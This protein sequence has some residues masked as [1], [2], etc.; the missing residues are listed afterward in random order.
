[1]TDDK[2]TIFITGCNGR[3][4][5][6]FIS[7]FSNRYNIIGLSR[8]DKILPHSYVHVKGDIGNFVSIINNLPKIDCLINNAVQY[9]IHDP[10]FYNGGILNELYINLAIP[11]ELSCYMHSIWKNIVGNFSILNI[12][13]IAGIN[14]Y[15]INQTTYAMCKTAMNRM[16]LDMNKAFMP[17]VRVNAIAPNSFPSYIATSK[18]I[19]IMSSIIDSENINGQIIEIDK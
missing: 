7:N 2:K 19:E 15:N 8:K 1:M 9:N 4:G 13:S 18:V 16:T 3:L 10:K 14:F 17:M 6:A 12:S 11:Y 5:T